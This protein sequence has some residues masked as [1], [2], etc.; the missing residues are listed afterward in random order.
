MNRFLKVTLISGVICLLLGIAL[1]FGGIVSGGARLFSQFVEAGG[2]SIGDDGWYSVR[3]DTIDEEVYDGNFEADKKVTQIEIED[4]SIGELI[5]DVYE[6]ETITV[7]YVNVGKNFACRQD[8][9]SL[10]I[11]YP[12]KGWNIWAVI[13]AWNRTSEEKR[14]CV[15][16]HM[17]KNYPLSSCS[18][19]LSAGEINIEQLNCK[20]IDISTSAGSVVVN[21][22]KAENADFEVD[23]GE[24]VVEGYNGGTVETNCNAGAISFKGTVNGDIVADCNM[25]EIDFTLSGTIEKYNYD[26]SSNLG[27]VYLNNEE[28]AAGMSAN[29]HKNHHG[30]YTITADCN[31]GEINIDIAE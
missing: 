20:E 17:P 16:I 11:E 30:N 22:L 4:F 23:A 12:G 27:A 7:E 5:F 31:M 1:V 19:D 29:L 8:G 14:P 24:I 15:R 26:V 25:G 18:I 21:E 10:I 13:K 28:Y 9:T 3:N 6:G 2:L